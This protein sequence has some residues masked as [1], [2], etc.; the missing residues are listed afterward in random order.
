MQEKEEEKRKIVHFH[1]VHTT[2]C[3]GDVGPPAVDSCLISLSLLLPK[4]RTEGGTGEGG[5]E[6]TIKL[7]ESGA[8][9]G[10]RGGGGVPRV[11]EEEERERG[12]RCNGTKLRVSGEEGGTP[13]P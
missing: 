9:A 7:G 3:M 11:K 13:S 8:Q 4:E 10:K 2:Y 12:T 5:R 6:G 1:S